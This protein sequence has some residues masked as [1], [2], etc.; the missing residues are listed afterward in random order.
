MPPGWRAHYHLN[1]ESLDRGRRVARTESTTDLIGLAKGLGT[2]TL[3]SPLKKEHLQT[4]LERSPREQ[5][6]AGG[7]LA[8]AAQGL[9][10]HLVIIAG[11]LEAVRLWTGADA[12][13]QSS[14]RRVGVRDGGPGF[15]LL[16]AASSQTQVQAV[17]DAQYLR[18]D[19]EELDELLGWS[20]LGAA[21]PPARRLKVLQNVPPENVHRLFDRMVERTVA[22]GETI[23][24][25]RQ[26]G[27]SYYLIAT[28]EAE[29][30]ATDPLTDETRLVNRLSDGDGFGEE[31]LL[32]EGNRTATVKMISPGRL[33]VLC[34]A[35]FDELLQPQMVQTIDAE[36]ASA[37][38][39][40]GE[41]RLL[42]CRYEMEYEESRIPGARLAP[43]DT[44]RHQ[45]V[46][47]LDSDASYIVYCRSGRRS[48]AAAFLLR[49]RGIRA[50][51]LAGG[52]QDWP[53]EVINGPG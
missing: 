4:L 49:E 43:L 12:R 35:D 20:H 52:I 3:F 48:R 15:A 51:S 8:D 39:V 31:A 2:T 16:C 18:I 25:Q 47:A 30:W 24:E 46:F 38:L 1:I 26:A 50:A 28:G 7:W 5:V 14:T 32:V 9:R 22:A 29:V 21:L 37:L 27:D 19:A 13:E 23:V 36:R 6:P 11:E 41:A 40:R 45:G 33:L 17:T 53:Y 44:L 34:K 42:D 10:D